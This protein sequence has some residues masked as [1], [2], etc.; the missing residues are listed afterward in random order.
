MTGQAVAYTR[1]SSE[2]QAA[3][4]G[5]LA[6][7]AD[8]LDLYCQL[9]GLEL[10]ATVSD[11]GVSGSV[12]FGERKGGRQVVKLLAETGARHVVALKLDRLFRSAEN[13]LAQTREW[14]KSGVAMHL[15]D[16]GGQAIDTKTSGGK[17]IFTVFA[18]FAEMERNLIG[19]RT[20]AVLWHKRAHRK[21]YA[22]TPLGFRREGVQLVE[23]DTEQAVLSRIRTMAAAG[24]SL[25][26]IARQLNDEG[27]PAKRGGKYYASTIKYVLEN[28]ALHGKRAA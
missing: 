6:M 17:M 4:G 25:N 16:F 18:A 22:P 23:D 13:A 5:S 14:D 20:R 15:V 7:Q 27:V 26:A 21:V 24:M 28:V 11:K 9:Q 3:F 19:E 2:E 1:V 12:P 8:R 10:V